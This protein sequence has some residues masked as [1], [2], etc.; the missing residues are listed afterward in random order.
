MTWL[1]DAHRDWHY[2][3][4]AANTNCPLDC[5]AGEAAAEEAADVAEWEALA[6]EERARLTAEAEAYRAAEKA[7]YEAAL[8]ADDPWATAPF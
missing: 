7:K 5:G 1:A 6:P 4:G 8:M 2:V 3:Y